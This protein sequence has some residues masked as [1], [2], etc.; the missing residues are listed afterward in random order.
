MMATSKGRHAFEWRINGYSAHAAM[1]LGDALSRL[2]EQEEDPLAVLCIGTDRS[3]GDALGPLVGTRLQ[4]LNAPVCI[5]GTLEN[6]VHAAN[7]HQVLH[8]LASVNRRILAIDASL[9]RLEAVGQITVGRGSIRP[10]AGVNRNLPAVGRYY[11]TATVNVGGF[12]EYFVLQN[13][14][15]A[16]V[17]QLSIVIADGILRSLNR[18]PTAVQHR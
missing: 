14:R 16:T 9:G 7:L 15:L 13:T 11:I 12:M 17:M 4:Q 8:S 3:T 6:P 5:K 1:D 18:H 10:G 2:W